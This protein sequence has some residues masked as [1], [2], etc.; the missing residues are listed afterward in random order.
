MSPLTASS[1]G[2]VLMYNL[3]GEVV[4]QFSM[5]KE[6]KERGIIDCKIWGTG[7]VCLTGDL[8]LVAVTNF[9]EPRAKRL[10]DTGLT[11][12]PTSWVVIEPQFTH[13]LNVEVFLATSSGTIIVVD[14][15]GFQDQVFYLPRFNP[16]LFQLLSNG[17]FTKMTVSPSGKLLACF[18]EGGTLWVVSTDFQKNFSQFDTKS[19]VPPGIFF[20]GDTFF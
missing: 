19:K 5:G 20:R 11:S 8:Q 1:D 6:C 2:T 15:G 18:T 17:A 7:L 3:Q 13:S 10:V 12:P 14:A 4:S 9:V 16:H